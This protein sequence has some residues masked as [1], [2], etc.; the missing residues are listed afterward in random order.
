VK[1]GDVDTVTASQFGAP[2]YDAPPLPGDVAVVVEGDGTDDDA[3]VGYVDPR[4]A[5]TAVPGEHRIPARNSD[6]QVVGVLWLRGDG[7]LELGLDPTDFVALASR[8]DAEIQALVDDVASL[9]AAIASGF[10]AVG[11]GGAASGSAARLS[12]EGASSAIP[13]TPQTV[14]SETVKV[15]P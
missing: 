13:H 7:T 3:V 12:F 10:T 4:N 15:Q 1:A 2:G 8:T 9:K 11:E 6:G 14:A 5:G